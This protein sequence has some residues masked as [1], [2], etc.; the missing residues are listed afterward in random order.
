VGIRAAQEAKIPV[1]VVGVGDPQSP[2]GFGYK[3]LDGE[4][5]S[6]PPTKLEEAP[7]KEI[8]RQTH[9]EY[10]PAHR[11]KPDLAGF[12]ETRIEP[13]PSREL[14]DDALPQ[15]HD[16]AVW[17]LIPAIVLFLLAWYIEP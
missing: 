17:F 8:A 14:P 12:F 15:P 16:R 13:H 3:R 9:G 2:T 5:E 10:L 1:H 4:E 7:L 6:V 11:E